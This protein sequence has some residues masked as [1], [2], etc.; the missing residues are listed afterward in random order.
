MWKSQKRNT[1]KILSV[2]PR[3]AL[4]VRRPAVSATPLCAAD[5]GK[6][7]SLLPECWHHIFLV[8]LQR[9]FLISAH[10]ID[11]ELSNAR[12]SQRMEFLDVRLRRSEQAEAIRNVIRDEIRVIAADFTMMKVIVLLP[13]AD[14][15]SERC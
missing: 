11:V 14:I 3:R 15:G 4:A 12:L 9:I 5:R 7:D 10:E 2:R 6:T 13:A 8:F 1:A